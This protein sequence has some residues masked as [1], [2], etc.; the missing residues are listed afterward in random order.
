MIRCIRSCSHLHLYFAIQCSWPT[1]LF[2]FLTCGLPVL[3]S[4]VWSTT[5]HSTV[6]RSHS[7][8]FV[9]SIRF[10]FYL[11]H[12]EHI[13]PSTTFCLPVGSTTIG[14]VDDVVPVILPFLPITI[15]RHFILSYLPVDIHLLIHLTVRSS[16]DSTVFYTIPTFYHLFLFIHSIVPD[17]ICVLLLFCLF[18]RVH[19]LPPFY[20]P[21]TFTYVHLF[22]STFLP[23][24][25]LTYSILIRVL[26]V[27]RPMQIS[28]TVP[29]H[30][31]WYYHS[32]FVGDTFV[33]LPLHSLAGHYSSSFDGDRYFILH[34]TYISFC[35]FYRFWFVL[36]SDTVLRWLPIRYIWST[37]SS[38]LM[39][40]RVLLFFYIGYSIH[41]H[42]DFCSYFLHHSISLFP[43]FL[44]VDVPHSLSHSTEVPGN[45]VLRAFYYHYH[46][47]SCCWPLALHSVCIHPYRDTFPILFIPIWWN[48]D[49][50]V[51]RAGCVTFSFWPMRYHCCRYIH[52]Y[53]YIDCYWIHDTIYFCIHTIYYH[54][55]SILS[56]C[57]FCS[58]HISIWYDT[59]TIFIPF[60]TPFIVFISPFLHSFLLF[61]PIYS[62]F[63]V[64]FYVHSKISVIWT[65]WISRFYIDSIRFVH[66][67]RVLNHS[68][69]SFWSTFHSVCSH[70]I[71][72]FDSDHI[73]VGFYCSIWKIFTSLRLFYI[74]SLLFHL[75]V[76]YSFE[77]WISLFIPIEFLSSC[78]IYIHVILTFIRFRWYICSFIHSFLHTIFILLLCDTFTT[79]TF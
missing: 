25:F 34:S 66:S 38:P 71:C 43:L 26:L 17:R 64:S 7:H 6:Y 61:L 49:I 12:L 75:I 40:R 8:R 3:C 5:I 52:V 76:L 74:H 31:T 9:I 33:Y 27:W 54:L 72:S 14:P 23:P 37:D 42:S 41:I 13:G 65:I 28:S 4:T 15:L 18:L 70:S 73:Y 29:H 58:F 35:S 24:H 11:P 10:R 67:V 1:L 63:H 69:H 32:T 46:S 22:D 51:L 62:L 36:Y 44:T 59:P 77:V 53:S 79:D 2:C 78:W 21:T 45:F 19:F 55:F 48:T 30:D 16:T 50:V 68:Y 56:H 39:D 57:L 20:T 47:F 60:S